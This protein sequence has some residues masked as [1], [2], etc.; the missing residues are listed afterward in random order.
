MSGV[1][2]V[3]SSASSAASLMQVLENKMQDQTDLAEKFVKIATEEKFQAA[4]MAGIGEIIDTY[5]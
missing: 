5:V 4:Q 2:G 3:S 1:S